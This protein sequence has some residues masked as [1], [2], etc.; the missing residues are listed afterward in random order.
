MES[1]DNVLVGVLTGLIPSFIVITTVIIMAIVATVFV[2]KK[3]GR[4][5]QS[6]SDEPEALYDYPH[7]PSSQLQPNENI[8]VTTNPA[9]YSVTA[10]PAYCTVE[11]AD[12]S[13][14]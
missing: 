12:D 13:V 2:M 9:Y 10:N 6:V 4:N 14:N 7:A 8:Q 11:T 3:R 5:V 1:S